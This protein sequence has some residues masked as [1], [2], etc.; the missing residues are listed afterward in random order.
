MAMATEPPYSRDLQPKD[1]GMSTKD[2]DTL[3]STRNKISSP[4]NED[5]H[6]V[7]TLEDTLEDIAEDVATHEA[8]E[9]RRLLLAAETR[10]QVASAQGREAA[11]LVARADFSGAESAL[12][13]RW[14]R[15]A[16]S[17]T[18]RGADDATVRE[19]ARH[20]RFRQF[21]DGDALFL[22]GHA[23]HSFFLLL[24]GTVAVYSGRSACESEDNDAAP[25]PAA[26]GRRVFTYREGDTFGEAALFATDAA[27]TASAVAAGACEVA[28]LARDVYA[29]TL[30]RAH[31]GPFE[32]AQRLHF[33]QR[34]SLFRDWG[35]PRLAQLADALELR[36]LSF[37]DVLLAEGELAPGAFFV[38]SG[39]LQLSAQLSTVDTAGPVSP[40]R[41]LRHCGAR[42]QR[43][44]VT[45]ALRTARAGDAVALQAALEPSWRAPF[46][47]TAASADAEVYLLPER[48]ARALL[49]GATQQLQRLADE[50]ARART[51]RL[52]AA[53]RALVEARAAAVDDEDQAD[54]DD[55]SADAK[56]PAAGPAREQP[57]PFVPHL[58]A[59]ALWTAPSA[60]TS[61]STSTGYSDV[62]SS[63]PSTLGLVVPAPRMLSS[64]ARSFVVAHAETLAPDYPRRLERLAPASARGAGTP[65]APL[66][67]GRHRQASDADATLGHHMRRL[68]EAK[69][70]WDAARR[71]LVLADGAALQAPPSTLK[72]V[73]ASVAVAPPT[74]R[75]RRQRAAQTTAR[76][77]LD[78]RA[79]RQ[80]AAPSAERSSAFV[81]FL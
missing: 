45:V 34:C 23:G 44:G 4:K 17:K 5:T 37:G 39:A 70:H 47:A 8:A 20:A 38:L 60:S 75:G 31:R 14:S 74:G 63:P 59:A 9:A 66:R 56:L 16:F 81:H 48:E 78:E 61:T 57:A 54:A 51:Q 19:V 11:A 28:E 50:D 3:T 67:N 69:V 72:P 13:V 15:R 80:T 77:L 53:R 55:C 73:S 58:R 41:R 10:R 22:E 2:E 64:C 68:Y 35:R 76:R 40:R 30:Q 27:R 65:V 33:L 21:A 46:A 62:R 7:D 71:G 25:D 29:R 26:L 79:Q 18:F 1:E 12:L 6:V 42:A 36:R 32:A 43:H 24:A 49:G 52:D